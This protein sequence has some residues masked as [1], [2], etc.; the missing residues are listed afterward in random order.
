M[1]KAQEQ[2]MNE[3]AERISLEKY[4]VQF[5]PNKIDK[6]FMVDVNYPRRNHASE[7]I[8]L[9]YTAAMKEAEVLVEA[10]EEAINLLQVAEHKQDDKWYRRESVVIKILKKF[11]GE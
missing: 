9:G 1:T 4:P 2:R 6:E 8:K 5:I 11:K 7:M 10:L 3:L